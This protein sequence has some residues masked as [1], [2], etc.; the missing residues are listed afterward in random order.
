MKYH[1]WHTKRVTRQNE[2]ACMRERE[3]T[4]KRSWREMS[5]ES[6]SLTRRVKMRLSLSLWST[7]T[8]SKAAPNAKSNINPYGFPNDD[9]DDLLPLLFSLLWWD[10]PMVHISFFLRNEK[11][12]MGLSLSLSLSLST[13]LYSLSW[14]QYML[15][16]L[17]KGLN[18]NAGR[19]L[20]V[21]QK[22]PCNYSLTL[23][24]KRCL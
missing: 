4:W 12:E 23:T 1:R 3:R 17:H 16:L 6:F 5:W 8:P 7:I 21:M 15:L 22:E 24:L 2:H 11:K 19:C 14:I 10:P 13:P 9:D 20:L 18:E